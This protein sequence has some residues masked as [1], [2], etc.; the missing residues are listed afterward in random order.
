MASDTIDGMDRL[1]PLKPSSLMKIP[2]KPGTTV[3]EIKS[4][5]NIDMTR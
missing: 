2:Q 4:N 3:R 5:N 1:E